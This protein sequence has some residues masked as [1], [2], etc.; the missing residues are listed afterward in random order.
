MKTNRIYH[1]LERMGELLKVSARHAGADHGLQPVHLEVLRYLSVCNRYSDTPMAVTEYLG[2]TKGTVSQTIKILEKKE[3]VRKEADQNDKRMTHLKVTKQGR[4]FID[5]N[6]PTDMFVTACQNLSETQQAEIDA[7]LDLLLTT[8]IRSN[9]MKSFGVCSSCQF[10]L[11]RG[12]GA[13]F[14]DL[15]KAPLTRDDTKLICRE[16]DAGDRDAQGNLRRL[17]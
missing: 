13:Y 14:C 10:N 15:V 11:K 16:H 1:Y 2:Q 9:H 12:E 17:K 5:A 3:L 4:D 6:L 8:M 7:A